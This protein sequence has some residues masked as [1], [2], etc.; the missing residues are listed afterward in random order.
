MAFSLKNEIKNIQNQTKIE[1]K[2]AKSKIDDTLEETLPL[3]ISDITADLVNNI[4][5]TIWKSVKGGSLSK[6]FEG[7]V[8]GSTEY[9]LT[10]NIDPPD[11]E[12][13]VKLDTAKLSYIA[14]NLKILADHNIQSTDLGYAEIT[15]KDKDISAF[16]ITLKSRHL[17]NLFLKELKRAA[18]ADNIKISINK[19]G[20]IVYKFVV[21]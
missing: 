16:S 20:N 19:A 12:K 6:V 14:W 4:K 10:V 8:L 13:F 17:R 9:M 7:E 3:L 5:N 1:I 18:K 21:R 15:S 11:F 2:N